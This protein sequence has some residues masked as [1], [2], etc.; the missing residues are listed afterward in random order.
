MLSSGT[1]PVLDPVLTSGAE[2]YLVGVLGGS[3]L[4]YP[5][6]RLAIGGSSNCRDTTGRRKC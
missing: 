4:S 1:R 2:L 6:G 5:L 3:F